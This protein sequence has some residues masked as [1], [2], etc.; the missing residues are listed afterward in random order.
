MGFI[1]LLLVATSLLQ[2]VHSAVPAG[3]K[4]VLVNNIIIPKTKADFQKDNAT[5]KWASGYPKE[6]GSED[7]NYQ[8]NVPD[9]EVN[10][11]A[12]I[13]EDENF[14][15]MYNGS[16]VEIVD[17]NKNT[18]VSG[19][20]F[21]V[22]EKLLA[23]AFSVRSA[24]QG[25]DV[26]VGAG[27]YKYNSPDTTLRQHV[28][29]NLAPVGP[30]ILYQGAIGAISKQGKLVTTAGYVYDLETTDDVPVATLS[31]QP[32]LSD[33]SFGPDGVHLSS[34]DWE[35]ET[36]DLWNATS[37]EKIYE[38]PATKAQNWFTRFSPDGKYVAFGLGSSNNTIQIYT[39]ANFT[40]A[41]I[42]IHGFNNWPR[43]MEWHPDSRHV[44]VGDDGRL[45]IYHLPDQSIIQTWQ[46]DAD[47]FYYPPTGKSLSIQ[48]NLNL[49][50]SN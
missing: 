7:F 46:V 49:G 48:L 42:E 43:Q 21:E 15:F 35:K 45:R 22:P 44:A 5:A 37:G 23:V 25:Y 17:L 2:A 30:K 6:W 1:S 24:T 4:S 16:Y 38:F 19:F 40:A 10:F 32:Q 9:P 14:L 3:V 8:L 26:L 36:A 12:V 41:P 39:L 33:F 50:D 18:T 13:T 31:G 20:V 29:T 47:S 28:G 11:N 27:T 34:V